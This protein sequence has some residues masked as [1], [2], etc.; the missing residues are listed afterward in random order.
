M[1]DKRQNTIDL[2]QANQEEID[3]N[4]QI[5]LAQLKAEEKLFYDFEKQINYNIYLP[6][7]NLSFSVK[8]VK[9]ETKMKKLGKFNKTF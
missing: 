7:N 1:L 8:K 5:Q 3:L 6:H 9:I 2:R 4:G